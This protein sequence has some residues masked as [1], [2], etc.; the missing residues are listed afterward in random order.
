M[1]KTTMKDIALRANVSVATVSYVLNRVGNQ[2]I[3]EK[4]RNQ[5]MQLA[6]E[7]HY[8][9]N[10]AARSLAN[11]R[12][13]LVGVLVN[14]SVNMPY[15]KLHSQFSFIRSLEQRLTAAGY[16]TLLYS[17][18][19]EK[20]SLD[21]I[22]ERKLEA[23]FL[24]DVRD[25]SFYSISRHFVEG[26]PLILI[27]SL[28]E[29]KLF[30]QVLFNYRSALGRIMPEDPSK[31]CLIMESYNNAQLARYIRDSLPLPDDAV[32]M[33]QNQE[34]LDNILQGQRF[35]EAIIINEFMGSYAQKAGSFERLFVVCTCNCPQIL[36]E[37]VQKITFSGDKAAAAF[38]LMTDLLNRSNYAEQENNR[39]FVD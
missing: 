24:I 1:K 9:P 16:H 32:F 23:V 15:W 11:R 26:I 8:I 13:G 37:Q 25:E 17:L 30:K 5:I 39:I 4:T 3:P 31:V 27:D 19:A 21:I 35:Q 6:E 29:D 28:I 33:V 10:L 38:E 34:E 2:T 12:T 14:T 18:D 7:L 22:I 36:G 20:P